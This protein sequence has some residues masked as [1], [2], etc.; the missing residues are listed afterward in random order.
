VFVSAQ[1]FN[2]PMCIDNDA[3]EDLEMRPEVTGS[4][5]TAGDGDADAYRLVDFC[6]RH[7]ISLA[8]FYKLKSK[9]L[10]PAI[11]YVGNRVL[12]SREAAAE[13]RRAREMESAA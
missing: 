13:W 4:K 9:G 11:F 6:R 12:I 8:M 1:K 5:V 2:I 7:G 3:R 10:A